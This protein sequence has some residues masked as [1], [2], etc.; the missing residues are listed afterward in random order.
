M[1]PTGSSGRSMR[2]PQHHLYHRPGSPPPPGGPEGVI[3]S[4]HGAAGVHGRAGTPAA[5]VRYLRAR[6]LGDSGAGVEGV[7]PLGPGAAVG[8]GSGS[9]RHRGYALLA[10]LMVGLVLLR[11][12][13]HSMETAYRAEMDRRPVG[14]YGSA[15]TIR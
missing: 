8:G 2:R 5:W 11:V 1:A 3:L 7:G 10:L 12:G 9:R 4:P 15:Y 14:P 6:L 13:R